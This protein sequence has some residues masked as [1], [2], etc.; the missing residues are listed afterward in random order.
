MGHINVKKTTIRKKNPSRPQKKIEFRKV[1]INN[2][3]Q[4]LHKDASDKRKG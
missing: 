4:R 3:L 2:Q 1:V